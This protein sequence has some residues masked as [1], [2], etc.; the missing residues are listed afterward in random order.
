LLSPRVEIRKVTASSILE[1]PHD[2]LVATA[3]LQLA[4]RGQLQKIDLLE[5]WFPDFPNSGKITVDDLLRMR[6]GT[7]GRQSGLHSAIG[8]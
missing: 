4:D 3:V 5:K 2:L 7:A 1:H 8:G 6:S